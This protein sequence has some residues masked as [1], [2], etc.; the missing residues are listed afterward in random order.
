MKTQTGRVHVQWVIM[1]IQLKKKNRTNQKT[2]KR[3]FVG[4]SK[5]VVNSAEQIVSD[6]KSKIINA[7]C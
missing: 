2:L 1:L 4:A 5:R 7:S 6:K 3:D